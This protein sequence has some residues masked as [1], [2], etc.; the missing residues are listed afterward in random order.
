MERK[1]LLIYTG[2]TI[3]M[4]KKEDG[5]FGPFNFAQLA[6]NV[7]ELD[8]L[9]VQ[10]DHIS[11]DEPIDSSNMS[12]DRWIELATLLFNNR[13]DYDG[14][15]VLHGSDTMAYTASAVSFLLKDFNKPI[16]FT[17]SQ[18]PIGLI[19][20]DAKENL[21]TAIEVA[22]TYEGDVPV[23]PETALYFEYRLYRGNRTIKANAELFKA[24]LSPNYPKLGEAGVHLNFNYKSIAEMRPSNPELVTKLCTDVA[25]LKLYPGIAKPIVEA[26]LNTP[27]LKGLIMET[28]GTGNASTEQW[29]IN[30]L[31]E[32]NKE[33]LFIVN[34]TQCFSGSVDQGRYETSTAFNEIGI[35]PADDMTT[36]A[37]LT[38]LMFVLA[39][40]QGRKRQIEVYRS[41]IRGEK[42]NFR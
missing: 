13:E 1:V 18:L 27:N 28:F 6:E 25:I 21:L 17:G 24:F 37:A 35:I 31:E 4:V 39:N 33:G 20:T 42:R 2:G 7:P 22:S 12:P 5:S 32:K 15:V 34:V 3:G 16:V 10:I 41:N 11:Y 30:I 8:K 23:V 9:P 29:F 26:V 19:R 14:F 36:E 40:V 38:K